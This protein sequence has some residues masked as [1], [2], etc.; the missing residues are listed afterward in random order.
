MFA[1]DTLSNEALLE[2][3][4][5]RENHRLRE[6][7]KILRSYRLSQAELELIKREIDYI[8]SFKSN[9]D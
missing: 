8:D 5:M 3:M 1:N 7:K 6:I 9:A 4:P 2:R